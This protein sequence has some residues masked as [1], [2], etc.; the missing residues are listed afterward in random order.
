MKPIRLLFAVLAFS[1][2]I[3]QAKATVFDYPLNEKHIVDIVELFRTLQENKIIRGD[4]KQIK[5]IKKINKNFISTGK[6]TIASTYGILWKMQDPFP[7]QTAI[8]K[9]KI[10]QISANGTQTEI[11]IS[12][13]TILQQISQTINAVFS[14]NRIE[15][16]NNFHVFF[17]KKDS[18][19]TIGLIPKENAIKKQISNI[20]LNG[21][22]WIDSVDLIDG[23]GVPL[24]YE[25]SNQEAGQSLTLD[26]SKLLY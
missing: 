5:T 2:M 20:I 9:T 26:E 10:T 19:W 21:E 14:G 12:G 18:K 25:F 3:T 6:F 13:N 1:L 24:H 7:S 11:N 16:Q 8:S 23:D 22:K 4:F 15:L 17:E